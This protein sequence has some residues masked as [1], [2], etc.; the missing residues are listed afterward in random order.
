MVASWIKIFEKHSNEF[1][2][3]GVKLQEADLSQDVSF[4]GM[5]PVAFCIKS[6]VFELSDQTWKSL[7]ILTLIEHHAILNPCKWLESIGYRVD[8]IPVD[9]KGIVLCN[10]FDGINLASIM[11]ANNEIGSIQPIKKLC[12]Q[13]HAAGT[14]FH[15]DAVQAVGHIEID[16][17]ELDIDFLSASAHKFN[18]PKGIGFLYAKALSLLTPLISGGSQEF[19]YRAGTENVASIVGMAVALKKNCSEIE[20]NSQKILMLENSLLQMLREKNIDF[21]RNG[22]EN[23]IPGNISLSFKNQNGEALLHRLDFAH[24]CVSTGSACDS[25]NTQVSHV[26]RSIGLPKEY[27]EGTIR[28]SL[29]KYNTEEDVAVIAKSLASI[30]L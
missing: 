20:Q 3:I 15:S 1:S 28:I 26:L 9:S 22:A 25:Q 12:E 23:H 13:A 6:D 19:G 27:A 5:K 30:L 2:K 17:K 10:S 4:T 11:F 7:Y 21:I 24:I 18:G 16:V 14:L 8:Y 29:G